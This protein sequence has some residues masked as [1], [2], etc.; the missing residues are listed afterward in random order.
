[1]K[2]YNCDVC[3]KEI[4]SWNTNVRVYIFGKSIEKDLCQKCKDK[5]NIRINLYEEKRKEQDEEFMINLFKK[6]SKE[7]CFVSE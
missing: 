2:S 1:V 3:K 7:I 6:K 4:N 5:I